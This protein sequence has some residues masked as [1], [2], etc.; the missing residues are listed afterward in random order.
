[1]VTVRAKSFLL[2]VQALG[3]YELLAVKALENLQQAIA[4]ATV[5]LGEAIEAMFLGDL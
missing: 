1:M 5:T 4:R 3:V 2:K